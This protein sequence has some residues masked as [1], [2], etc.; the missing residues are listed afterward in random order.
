MDPLTW[1]IAEARGDVLKRLTPADKVILLISMVF[2]CACML[3]KKTS[4][5][6]ARNL[7][8][9]PTLHEPDQMEAHGGKNL[10]FRLCLISFSLLEDYRFKTSFQRSKM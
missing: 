9:L 5:Q 6:G 4:E 3:C 8:D 1:L 7:D 10:I 2:C